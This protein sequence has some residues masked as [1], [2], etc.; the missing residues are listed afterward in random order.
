[1]K[2]KSAEKIFKDLVKNKKKYSSRVVGLANLNLAEIEFRKA[3]YEKALKLY[4]TASNFDLPD[5]GFVK[6][7]QAWCYV[8][9]GQD[10]KAISIMTKLLSDPN[11]MREASFQ[12]DV[13]FDF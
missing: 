2:E 6:H 12:E 7:R 8:N 3:N 10:K 11:L 4:N 1:S 9:I 5:T 13:S